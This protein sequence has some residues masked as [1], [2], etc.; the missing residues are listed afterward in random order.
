[1]I[2]LTPMA[3]K[4]AINLI[5]SGTTIAATARM[6]NISYAQLYKQI[7]DY[8]PFGGYRQRDKRPIIDRVM[9]HVR[10]TS[11]G[12]WLWVGPAYPNI[13]PGA[14]HTPRGTV[15]K[16]LG[17]KYDGP[18]Y[19]ACGN[20]DCCNPNHMDASQFSP[21]NK[22]IRALWER[23]EEAKKSVVTLEELGGRY[24]L[25]KQRIQQILVLE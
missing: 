6:M 2:P 22:E 21:R 16:A 14:T 11:D 3:I 17:I 25:T 1:M 15:R 13:I 12:H 10:K 5:K 7:K 19:P 9:S 18:K 24:G 8:G 4:N 23:S 20:R